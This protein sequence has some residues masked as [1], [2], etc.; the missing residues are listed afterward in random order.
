M[1]RVSGRTD[2]M[3]IIRGV[4]VFPSEIERALLGI[5]EVAPHYLIVVERRDALDSLEIRIELVAG[6][7]GSAIPPPPDDVADQVAQ[8]L[9]AALG[10]TAAVTI[11]PSGSLPRSEGKAQR[12][13]DRRLP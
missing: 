8:V 11:H 2:D 9:A 1:A 10:L 4:N 5:P 13:L 6:L 7:D 12:V 3:L